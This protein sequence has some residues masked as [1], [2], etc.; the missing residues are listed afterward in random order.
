MLEVQRLQDGGSFVSS[1][2]AHVR[3]IAARL[4]RKELTRGAIDE[5]VWDGKWSWLT[6]GVERVVARSRRTTQV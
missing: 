4:T 2:M 1:L 6:E 3:C 5:Q